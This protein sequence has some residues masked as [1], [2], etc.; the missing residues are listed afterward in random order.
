M[1]DDVR[2]F[3]FTER[4][5]R[6]LERWLEEDEETGETL[7]VFHWIRLNL[8][9]VR[10]DVDLMLRVIR[11]L[12]LRRRWRGRRTGRSE[13]GSRLRRAESALTH[14]RRGRATSDA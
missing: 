14:A 4:E 6:L 11:E 1:G 10:E 3:I 13:F 8:T 2:G 7:K 12:R 9:Q 5:R